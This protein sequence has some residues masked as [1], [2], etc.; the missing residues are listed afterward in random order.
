M[1]EQTPQL[2]KT[3]EQTLPKVV[4]QQAMDTKDIQLPPRSAER[5]TTVTRKVSE[6]EDQRQLTF[7]PIAQRLALIISLEGYPQ[8]T[9]SAQQLNLASGP[10]CNTND[11]AEN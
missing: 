11:I 4:F 7:L 10:P 2:P 9:D 1:S 5:K 8:S 6:V 3:S